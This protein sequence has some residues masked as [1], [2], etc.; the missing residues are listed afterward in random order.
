MAR[1]ASLLP[2]RPTSVVA[3]ALLVTTGCS[4]HYQP[5]LG[6]R[7]SVILDGGSIAYVRDGQKYPHGFMGGGLVEAV[8]DDPEAKEAAETHRSYMTSGFI[9]YLVGTACLVAG[10]VV[11]IDT[12]DD[13]EPHG[14]KDAI[15][16]GGVLCGLTGGI[17]GAA[18]MAAGVPYQY[19]A[20][21]IYN[22]NV[23]RRRAA[24]PLPMLPPGYVPY[25]P[26]PS[27][28]PLPSA[29]PAPTGAQ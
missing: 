2:R 5:Q 9:V 26:V 16:A 29:P 12:I 19:D 24:Q 17:A 20:I 7:L 28:A 15:A 21:N 4:S 25:V 13:P 10:V 11:A 18:L 22:D 27:P 1:A 14:D 8:E 3:L 6:P 23:E